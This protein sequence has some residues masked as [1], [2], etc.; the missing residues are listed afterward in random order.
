MPKSTRLKS[1]SEDLNSG[2]PLYPACDGKP[3]TN[4]QRAKGGEKVK[5]QFLEAYFRINLAYARL[6]AYRKKRHSQLPTTVERSLLQQIERAILDRE[7]VEDRH[8]SRGVVA[9]PIYRDGFTVDLLFT[10]AHRGR[11]C[12]I[13]ASS[14]SARLII[15]LP[16]GLRSKLCKS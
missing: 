8:A 6:M 5:Q 1:T 12:S 11:G 16:A 7:A 3:W 13:I 9:T 10:H 14:S 15:A 2:H 4:G